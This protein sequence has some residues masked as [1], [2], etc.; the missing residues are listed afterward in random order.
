MKAFIPTGS[1]NRELAERFGG[2]PLPFEWDLR[3]SVAPREDGVVLPG[4]LGWREMGRRLF[5]PPPNPLP[6]RGTL[7]LSRSG[8]ARAHL[9]ASV[10]NLGEYGEVVLSVNLVH[11]DAEPRFSSWLLLPERHGRL[12]L[13]VCLDPSFRLQHPKFGEVQASYDD[14]EELREVARGPALLVARSLG[15]ELREIRQET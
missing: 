14:W 5:Q 7:E 10:A 9:G 13:E 11:G 6:R 1:W 2:A 8:V 4:S 3:E 15:L 12:S